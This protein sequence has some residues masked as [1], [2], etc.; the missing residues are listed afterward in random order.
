MEEKMSNKH[1]KL[2]MAAANKFDVFDQDGKKI[3][4]ITLVDSCHMG[5]NM[6]SVTSLLRDLGLQAKPSSDYYHR[7]RSQGF[8][9]ESCNYCDRSEAYKIAKSSGQLFNDKF[10]L[11]NNKLD[12][13]CI[14]HIEN[15]K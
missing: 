4:S 5:R 3:K 2:I 13:S 15:T 6:Q 8:I 9:D 14:R 7:D 12:S 11:P 10:T 1:K